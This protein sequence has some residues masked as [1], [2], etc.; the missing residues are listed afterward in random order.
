MRKKKNLWL[1]KL[2]KQLLI[3]Q[4]CKKDIAYDKVIG[5]VH[6]RNYPEEVY[7]HRIEE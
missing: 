6:E 7:E 1:N 4:Q 5:K 3:L 2:E